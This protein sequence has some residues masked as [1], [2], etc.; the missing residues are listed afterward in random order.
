MET[1]KFAKVGLVVIIVS[2]LLFTCATSTSAYTALKVSQPKKIAIV[3]ED[4]G[5]KC[6]QAGLNQNVVKS[7]V[8]LRLRSNGI[9]P[10]DSQKVPYLHLVITCLESCHMISLEFNREIYYEVNETLHRD[11]AIVWHKAFVASGNRTA[12]I[13]EGLEE[14]I[15]IFINAYLTANSK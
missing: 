12:H 7:K 2:F 4:L 11:V 8:E 5:P 10:D 6:I 13:I 14:I 1:D 3:I 15:D 9:I